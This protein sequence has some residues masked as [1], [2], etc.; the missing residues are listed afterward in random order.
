MMHFGLSSAPITG[1][2]ASLIKMK[3]SVCTVPK[4]AANMQLKRCSKGFVSLF[5]LEGMS[6]SAKRPIKS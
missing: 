3:Q 4:A 1:W 2:L 5:K 6:S